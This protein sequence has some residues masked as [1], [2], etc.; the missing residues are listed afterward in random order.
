RQQFSTEINVR[1]SQRSLAF[2]R[3]IGTELAVDREQP[4]IGLTEPG[5]LFLA[6]TAGQPVLA[7]NHEVQ[8][9][10]G[11]DVALLTPAEVQARFPC[12]EV[13]D[14]A[15]ASLGRT[16]EGWFDG[17]S[18]LQAFRRKAIALGARFVARDVRELSARAG[19]TSVVLDDRARLDADVALIAAG[20]WSA[21]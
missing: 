12:L 6:S 1:L 21:P 18:V 7:A 20:A 9:R 13:R 8:T 19:A 16:G 15:A 4:A 3:N 2:L 5:Y 10:C 17:Y 14:L 11:A